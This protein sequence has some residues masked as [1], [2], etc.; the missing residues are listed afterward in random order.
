MVAGQAWF[1]QAEVLH[2]LG[3]SSKWLDC[4]HMHHQ[5]RWPGLSQSP[6]D[7]LDP[8]GEFCC[9]P[10]AAPTPPPGPP[11]LWLQ[12]LQ[13]GKLPAQRQCLPC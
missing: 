12:G 2:P 9:R 4:L 13:A 5:W 6:A 8:V 1:G 10:R 7:P 3:Q 11:G